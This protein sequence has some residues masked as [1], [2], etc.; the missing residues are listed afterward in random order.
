MPSSELH[1]GGCLKFSHF[2][3]Q[4][5]IFLYLSVQK[6]HNSKTGFRYFPVRYDLASIVFQYANRVFKNWR[7]SAMNSM[8]GCFVC[9]AD[10]SSIMF[11]VLSAFFVKVRM[12]FFFRRT[13]NVFYSEHYFMV[14]SLVTLSLLKCVLTETTSLKGKKPSVIHTK[15]K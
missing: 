9:A 4:Y 6:K 12:N 7:I 15:S 14:I 10:S 8:R 11:T 1:V 5:P 3:S 13:S 2:L